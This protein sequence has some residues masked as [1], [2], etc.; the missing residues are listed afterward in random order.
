MVA[1]ERSQLRAVEIDD[2]DAL[3]PLLLVLMLNLSGGGFC[4]LTEWW[5]ELG[6]I[7][8]VNL[9]YAAAGTTTPTLADVRWVRPL[10]FAASRLAMVGMRF[11]V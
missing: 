9:P 8:R 10:P 11:I 2:V 4:C 6:Q 5:P 7:V 1:L 3:P